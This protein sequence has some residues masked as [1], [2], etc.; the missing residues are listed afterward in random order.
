MAGPLE[1]DRLSEETE[2]HRGNLRD[3]SLFQTG[4]R[5]TV[6]LYAANYV[7]NSTLAIPQETFTCTA[8]NSV[9][10]A[11]KKFKVRAISKPT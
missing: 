8:S 7:E 11:T 10:N 9:G 5:N 3:K 2:A 1:V 6:S 4:P